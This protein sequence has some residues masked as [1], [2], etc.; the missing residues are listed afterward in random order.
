VER[1]DKKYINVIDLTYKEL[2]DNKDEILK[3]VKRYANK[4]TAI[5]RQK[6][7]RIETVKEIVKKFNTQKGL[8][9]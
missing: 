9:R 3:D 4:L 7:S 6:K 1:M 8:L 2:E 5:N